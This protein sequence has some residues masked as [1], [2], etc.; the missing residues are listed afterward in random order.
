MRPKA[1]K[2]HWNS[3]KSLKKSE[4]KVDPI[5]RNRP[6]SLVAEDLQKKNA[7]KIKKK[8]PKNRLDRSI[9]AAAI[10]GRAIESKESRRCKQKIEKHLKKK[11]TKWPTVAILVTS[12]ENERN[13]KKKKDPIS[14]HRRQ[15]RDARAGD[16]KAFLFF[17]TF[18]SDS[19]RRQQNA[20]GNKETVQQQ[21]QQQQQQQPPPP[22]QQQQP[23]QYRQWRPNKRP[24]NKTQSNT[25]RERERER[26]REPWKPPAIANA[27]ARRNPVFGPANRVDEDKERERERENEKRTGREWVG[28]W[29]QIKRLIRYREREINMEIERRIDERL[30][31]S[32]NPVRNDED[33]DVLF[34]WF[35]CL[36]VGFSF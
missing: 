32:Q 24:S 13:S 18:S 10:K 33:P 3:F 6:K 8:T 36:L 17:S 25:E 12:E 14:L 29:G 22:Q 30:R 21:Q 23:L 5:K 35:V 20:K 11:N 34:C 15:R 4:S 27:A 16:P 26:E 28:G 2:G 31:R 19:S 1:I 9:G 7:K